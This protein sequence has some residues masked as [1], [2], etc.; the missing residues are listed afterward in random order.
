M[1]V[2]KRFVS[3]LPNTINVRRILFKQWRLETSMAG[4]CDLTARRG[5]SFFRAACDQGSALRKAGE[6]FNPSTFGT[7]S[8]GFDILF[9]SEWR[10]DTASR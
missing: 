7:L 5:R 3:K 6:L 2:C 4:S 10:I 8:S 9:T 1:I